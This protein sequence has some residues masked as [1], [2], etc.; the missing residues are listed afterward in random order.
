LSEFENSRQ[1]YEFS[2]WNQLDDRIDSLDSNLPNEILTKIKSEISEHKVSNYHFVKLY[3][4]E[5]K[6]LEGHPMKNLYNDREDRR[7]FFTTATEPVPTFD[8]V[9]PIDEEIFERRENYEQTEII[10]NYNI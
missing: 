10:A 4:L 6:Y 2:F 1:N 9:Q 5:D 7:R 8:T 3:K